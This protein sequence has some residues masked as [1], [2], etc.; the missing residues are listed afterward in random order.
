MFLRRLK[1]MFTGR[2]M[3]MIF[4]LTSFVIVCVIVLLFLFGVINQKDFVG[5]IFNGMLKGGE[6]TANI[7]EDVGDGGGP[8]K[9]TSDGVYIN[10]YEP[11]GSDD[12]KEDTNFFDTFKEEYV[13][14]VGEVVDSI[15]VAGSEEN[16]D[17]ETEGD[18]E[19]TEESED[20]E[21]TDDEPSE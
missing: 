14:K 21:T 19:E 16:T 20:S 5:W 3:R 9:V 10:G 4:G 2:L 17:T 12:I 6:A 13:D 7:I 11:E 1:Y 8:V 15:P 18:S